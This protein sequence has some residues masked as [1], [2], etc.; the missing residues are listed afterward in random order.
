MKEGS[1][2]EWGTPMIRDATEA[3]LDRILAIFNHAVVN[4]TAVYDYTERS[5]EAQRQWF[6]AK[7]AAG[8]PVLVAEEDGRVLGF[9]SYGPFRPWPAYQFTVENSLYVDPACFGRGVGS[10]LLAETI[11]RA[12]AAGRHAMLAGIDAANAVSLRLH[13]KFGFREAGRLPEVGWKFDRWLD[14]VFLQKTL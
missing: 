10:A 14:L 5:P 6:A 4:T 7:Q 11:E 2:Q 9:A 3:D 1:G 12:R 13:E 8:L